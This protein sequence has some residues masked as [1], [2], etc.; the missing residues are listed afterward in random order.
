[1]HRIKI[2]REPAHTPV[3]MPIM[4]L[5]NG[6]CEAAEG[7]GE[8]KGVVVAVLLVQLDWHPLITRQLSKVNNL[9]THTLERDL[10][11]IRYP[12]VPM[13]LSTRSL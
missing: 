2:S 13:N 9:E 1:M 11:V 7:D 8:G 12:T 6:G 10:L 4:P 5:D 3:M